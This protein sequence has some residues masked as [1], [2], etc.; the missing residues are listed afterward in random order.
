MS[1]RWRLAFALALLAAVATATTAVI[2]YRSTESRLTYETDR[3]LSERVAALGRRGPFGVDLRGI[4]GPGG[5]GGGGSPG[6]IVADLVRSDVELQLID[7]TGATLVRVGDVALPVDDRDLRLAGG[8]GGDARFRTADIDGRAFRILTVPAT[9]GALQLGRNEAGNMN[10]LRALRWRFTLVGGSVVTAAVLAGWVIARRVTTPLQRLTRAAEHIAST[11]DLVVE[12]PSLGAM[13]GRTDETGRLT[14]A[15]ETML[16][17]LN[18]SRASQRQLVQDAGHELRTPLT[19]LRTNLDVLARHPDLD[20]TQRDALLGDVR[21][22]LAELGHLV[23][24]LV[25]LA[26]DRLDD[27]PRQRLDLTAVAHRI[28]DRAARRHTRT[29]TVSGT[30]AT[31]AARRGGIDRALGNLVDNAAKFSPSGSPVEIT[32]VGGR[33]SVRDHGPGIDPA[34]LDRVFDRFYRATAARSLPGSGLGLAIVRREIEAEGGRV[35][36]ANHPDG[37]AVVGFDLPVDGPPAP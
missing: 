12:D 11:G 25:L 21:T 17:T 3:F 5:R 24:E 18:R 7:S 6:S 10:V 1:L 26:A 16:D 2:A 35:F 31:V 33:V 36:A 34:D 32:L 9:D 20:P 14:R 13:A 28:G 8:K 22:E 30:G 37:G 23:D 27:E 4:G 19:S 29:V 15:W